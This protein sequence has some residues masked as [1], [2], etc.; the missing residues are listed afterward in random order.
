[1]NRRRG[2][3]ARFG[4]FMAACFVF[5]TVAGA[6]PE[7]KRTAAEDPRL[8]GWDESAPA[9]KPA[10]TPP[11]VQAPAPAAPSDSEDI[12]GFDAF[13][14]V[15]DSAVST[16]LVAPHTQAS[17][18]D[19]P[20]ADSGAAPGLIL[21]PM[22]GT[23]SDT[24]ARAQ[25][26][27]GLRLG[28]AESGRFRILTE[29]AASLA[30]PG[31]RLPSACFEARCVARAAAS[32]PVPLVLSTHLALRDGQWVLRLVLAQ[33][34]GGRIRGALQVWSKTVPGGLIPFAREAG[35]RL[36]APDR[37]PDP[38][39][40]S[41]GGF[42]PDSVRA[43]QRHP[44]SDGAGIEGAL[45]AS[46]PWRSIPWLNPKDSIDHRARTGWTG[47][48]L[49]AAGAA[50]AYAQGQLTG[51]DDNSTAP[52]RALASASGPAS[53]LRGFFA[54]PAL[55]ARFAAMGGAG[56]AAVADGISLLMNPAGVAGAERENVVMAKRS[57][58]DGTPSFFVAYAGPLVGGWH[59][60]LGAQYEGDGLANETTLFGT[61][62]CDLGILGPA[63][64]GVK[65][66]AQAKLYLAQ[67]GMDGTGQDRSTGHSYGMGWDFGVQ[68][69][70]SERITAALSVRDAF[71]FLRHQNTFTDRSYGEILPIEWKVGAAYRADNGLTFL[72]DGQK[73]IWADQAD[74]LRV[75]GEQ[76]LW[77]VLALRGGLHETFGRET[78]RAIS[79][80]FGLDTDGLKEAGLKM[81]L[82]LDYAFEFGLEEDAPLAG[83]QQFSLEAGF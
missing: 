23:G 35:L 48:G 26:T 62:A 72:L 51:A 47:A 27:A 82:S 4:I 76:T 80:G 44:V 25:A 32:A 8:A 5:A 13:D 41:A 67:A 3:S 11:P 52:A 45:F 2:F 9:Q 21:L 60:G 58:P 43:S 14:S 77:D 54:S 78:V 59:Q 39:R 75:G 22:A 6:E 79:V 46:G 40:D 20:F 7:A 83:G 50:L 1:V 12:G 49:L 36:A 74:H 34:P 64:E 10:R 17:L 18:A 42:D 56:V 70:L 61:L 29:E 66:G 65:A 81:R 19:E 28:L 15:T 68:A 57:L 37:D 24:G 38:D 16:R 53:Y 69:P 30:W 73:G 33:A 71:G 31:G 63:W 55:G